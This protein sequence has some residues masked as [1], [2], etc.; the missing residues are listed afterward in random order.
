[1]K[2]ENSSENDAC[3]GG[4]TPS[5]SERRPEFEKCLGEARAA[6]FRFVLSLVGNAQDAEDVIQRASITMWRRFSDFEKGTNFVA[7]SFVV[8]SFE[9]KNFLRSSSRSVVRFDEELFEKLAREREVDIQN[10][11]T[12]LEA[13]EE[14]MRQLDPQSKALVES[15]YIRGEEI[16]DLAQRE[17]RAPQTFYNRLNFIRRM[18]TDCL[19]QNNNRKMS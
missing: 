16:K 9:A 19:R 13:L 12:R 7:W 18:L 1:M 11:D 2:A 15:V 3:D 14:C 4:R 17:G 10:D 8:A 6:L 5:L